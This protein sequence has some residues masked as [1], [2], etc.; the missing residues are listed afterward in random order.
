[1]E[2]GG[3][4][5]ISARGPWPQGMALEGRKE[6]DGERESFRKTTGE[7]FPGVPPVSMANGYPSGLW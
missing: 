1:M 3:W 7:D 4:A 6:E 2:V 5:E